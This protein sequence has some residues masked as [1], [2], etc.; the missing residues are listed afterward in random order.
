MAETESVS[1]CKQW[2]VQQWQ[3]STFNSRAVGNPFVLSIS[4]L[5][6]SRHLGLE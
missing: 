2:D 4:E 3:E 1:V 6:Q 5:R